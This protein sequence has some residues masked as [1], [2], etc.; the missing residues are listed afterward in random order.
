MN[1]KE[2]DISYK[3]SDFDGEIDLKPLIRIIFRC[4]K[5]IFFATAI[6]SIYSVF[7]SISTYLLTVCASRLRKETKFPQSLCFNLSF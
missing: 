3:L 4:K 1:N 7:Y 5:F 6:S 2:S